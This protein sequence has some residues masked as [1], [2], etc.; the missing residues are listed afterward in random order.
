MK[1]MMIPHTCMFFPFRSEYNNPPAP[2]GCKLHLRSS[3]P[4]GK[5]SRLYRCLLSNRHFY[6]IMS[7]IPVLPSRAIHQNLPSLQTFA[8]INFPNPS[9]TLFSFSS[10]LL[11]RDDPASLAGDASL[12]LRLD[13]ELPVEF[14]V[15][16]RLRSLR[17][18][19][20]DAVRSFELVRSLSGLMCMLAAEGARRLGF[21]DDSGARRRRDSVS[22][23]VA[24]ARG[25]LTERS[26]ASML[27]LI[28]SGLRGRRGDAV[29]GAL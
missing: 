19:V 8:R 29:S 22:S 3:S 5:L 18:G 28:S 10:R 11:V 13:S 6:S 17:T 24:A 26:R 20:G 16:L 21:S 4:R 2:C 15:S 12:C 7:Y 25:G 14:S 9:P 27:T 23:G 1:M